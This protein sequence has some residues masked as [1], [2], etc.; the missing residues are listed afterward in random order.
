MV[1][2]YRQYLKICGPSKRSSVLGVAKSRTGP[3]LANMVDG[4]ISIS[5]SWPKTPGQ[6]AHREQGNCHDA[7]SKH[8]A[9]VLVSSEEQPHVTLPIFSKNNVGS[10]LDLVQKTQS[11]QSPYDKKKSIVF[12][13]ARYIVPF[14]VS[15][16]L[17]FSIVCFGVSF[18]DRTK[19]IMIHR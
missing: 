15:V 13:W 4:P 6:R 11:Q 5:I 12:G 10:L 8:Q 14:L 9:K 17:M 19:S 1:P 16:T 18:P 7:I 3:N 2:E